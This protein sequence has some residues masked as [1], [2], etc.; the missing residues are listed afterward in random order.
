MHLSIH[1]A[2]GAPYSLDWST[3]VAKDCAVLTFVRRGGQLLLI[4]KKRGLG[5]GK[6]NAPGGRIEAGETP[7]A[8][9]VRE[10]QEEL[11]VTP[12]GL[13]PAGRLYFQF[14]DGYSINC[15][16]FVAGDAV[17]TA[18]ETEEAV[19][20]WCAE[21]AIPY[22]NMWADDRL[23]LPLLLEGRRFEAWFV[24]DGDLMLWHE[25]HLKPSLQ[26]AAAKVQA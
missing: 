25:L 23:W 9:A 18:T 16:V 13:R 5:A 17:G 19:P 2:A 22:H 20:F 26:N 15:H 21:D 11:C 14:V 24:F 6:Y 3:W 1:T 7:E 4:L 12:T 10:T 8:A